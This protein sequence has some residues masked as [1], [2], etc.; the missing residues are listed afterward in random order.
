MA[1]TPDALQI[2]R[3]LLLPGAVQAQVRAWLSEDVPSGFDVGGFVVGGMCV[4]TCVVW[5]VWVVGGVD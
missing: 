2:A 5:G 3:S 1:T 4:R